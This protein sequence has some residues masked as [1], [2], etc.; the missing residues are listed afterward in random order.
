MT[1]TALVS[2]ILDTTDPEANLGF[3]AWLDGYK[4]FDSDHVQQRQ[5]VFYEFPDYAGQHRLRLALKNKLH[6]HTKLDQQGAI[7][8]DALL[9]VGNICVNGLNIDK[10][11][12]ELAVYTHDTN[13]SSPLGTYKFYGNMGCNGHVDLIFSTPVYLWLLEQV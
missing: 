6:S 11:F 8:R 13:G 2:C 1:P 10:L 4:F 12:H 5:Q 7:E 9:T 3:E